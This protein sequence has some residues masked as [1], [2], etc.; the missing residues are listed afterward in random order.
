MG[1]IVAAML[2]FVPLACLAKETAGPLPAA[3][4][5]QG[6][7]PFGAVVRR[8]WPRWSQGNDSVTKQDLIARIVSPEYTGENA[9][10]LVALEV[11]LRKNPSVDL[12]TAATIDDEKIVTVYTN[13]VL[14]LR[15]ARRALFANGRP[16]FELLQ[17]GPPGDC[18]F[19]SASGWMA[20]NRPDDVMN[21]ITPLDDGRFR[22]RFANGDEA[23][24]TPPTD[25]ELA[26]NDSDSTLQDGLW[27]SVLEKATGVIQ[28]RTIR[29][30]AELPDPTVA[31]DIPG[32]PIAGII[33]RWTGREVNRYPLGDRANRERV[34]NGLV[35]MHGRKSLATALLLHRP[36]AKLPFDHVYAILDFDPATDTVTIWN[37]WGTDFTPNGPS[38][39]ENGYERKK[40]VFFLTL[41]E[42]ITFYTFLAIEQN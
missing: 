38:G 16:T 23:V 17:Q 7:T 8:N 41:D 11:Y 1:I 5:L 24:V 35:R 6:I 3:K 14:K 33:K 37:P 4:E 21:A 2:I 10:S 27:M 12:A 25:A 22:V 13:N 32:V 42:F 18:Y 19:F 30:S 36:P 20:K 34:R 15:R 9:A 40:G 29:K 26:I 39:P 31:I 28:A